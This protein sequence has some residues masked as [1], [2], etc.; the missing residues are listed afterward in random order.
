MTNQ[1]LKPKE[2]FKGKLSPMQNVCTQIVAVVPM[3]NY[4]WSFNFRS[5][6]CIVMLHSFDQT[7]LVLWS[8]CMEPPSTWQ[9]PCSISKRSAYKSFTKSKVLIK[10]SVSRLFFQLNTNT[11]ML[12]E[13]LLQNESICLYKILSSNCMH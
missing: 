11:L 10:L 3:I 4:G 9:T 2:H 5:M 6:P 8:Y 7:I 12:S 1:C 13:K